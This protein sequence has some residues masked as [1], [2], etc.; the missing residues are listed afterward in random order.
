MN[1]VSLIIAV[2]A[3]FAA[4]AGGV[5]LVLGPMWAHQIGLGALLVGWVVAVASIA[6]EYGELAAWLAYSA[7]VP[8]FGI[9]YLL[10][11]V[12]YPHAR[13]PLILVAGTVALRIPVSADGDRYNLLIPLYCVIGILCIKELWRQSPSIISPGIERSGPGK[14][15]E[16]ALGAFVVWATVSLLW[17][18]DIRQAIVFTAMFALPF[19]ALYCIVRS[20]LSR[21]AAEYRLRELVAACAAVFIGVMFLSAIIG[22]GQELFGVVWQNPK[23]I[24][25]NAL[26]NNFRTNSIFWDPNMYGRYLVYALVIACV[27]I[28]P[29]RRTGNSGDEEPEKNVKGRLRIPPSTVFVVAAVLGLGMWFT[30]SQSSFLALSGASVLLALMLSSQ[31]IVVAS[32]IGVTTCMVIIAPIAESQGVFDDPGRKDVATGGLKIAAVSPMYGSGIASF[33][34]A[35]R[36]FRF[37]RGDRGSSLDASHMTPVTV[38]V[39]LG[40]L[41]IGIYSAFLGSIALAGARL[42]QSLHGVA[43]MHSYASNSSELHVT[44]VRVGVGATAIL[45][46]TIVHSMMY[47]S[48]FE[49]PIVWVCAAV[50]AWVTRE[51]VVVTAREHTKRVAARQP[52]GAES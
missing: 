15:V 4:A 32:I 29:L 26:D 47:A 12:L 17:T 22:I 3:S 48:F 37:D 20:E 10:A 41:G 50:L 13:L 30:Y 7:V 43:R 39:E 52:I 28:L 19:T 33:Q 44:L 9:G 45:A 27:G 31:R 2:T 11:R 6:V 34:Q 46:V 21:A 51:G 1:D 23:V 49:D 8:C 14:L 25:A 24:V 5:T 38:L 40:V 18:V 36:D 35:Y 16:Y 42:H